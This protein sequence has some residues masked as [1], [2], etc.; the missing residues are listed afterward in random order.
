MDISV[1]VSRPIPSLALAS[2]LALYSGACQSSGGGR[3]FLVFGGPDDPQQDLVERV[4]RAQEE[5]KATR[6][7]FEQAFQLFQR[8][9]APQAVELEELCEDFED[10]LESCEERT[11]RLGQRVGAVRTSSEELQTGWRAELE[12][13]SSEAMREK[14]EAQMLATDE[15]AQAVL[16]TLEE[17]QLALGPVLMQLQDYALFFQHNLNPRAIATLQDT[18]EDFESEMAT[19]RR[20]LDEVDVELLAFLA[21]HE[22]PSEP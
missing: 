20:E 14:S 18:Y 17:V 22:T 7:D 2:L 19:L 4:H 12:H 3:S 9:S 13:F 6:A 1:H 21:A 11:E 16:A 8:V 15:R 5:C 10:A